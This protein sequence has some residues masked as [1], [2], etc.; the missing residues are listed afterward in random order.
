MLPTQSPQALGWLA[1]TFP[2][3]T[4][5]SSVEVPAI[6]I[7]GLLDVAVREYSSWQQLHLDDKILKAEVRKACDVALDD[8]LDLTQIDKDKDPNYFKTRGVKWDIARRFIKDIRY[9]AESYN[10]CVTSEADI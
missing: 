3:D 2:E 8:G 10:G 1:S 7:P 5:A 4:T 6:H 9:W